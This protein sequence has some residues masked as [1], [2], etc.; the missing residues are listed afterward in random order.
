[1]YNNFPRRHRRIPTVHFEDLVSHP[2]L[3]IYP[4]IEFVRTMLAFLVAHEVPP[5]LILQDDRRPR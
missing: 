3:H 1:M 5:Y 2:L 4:N